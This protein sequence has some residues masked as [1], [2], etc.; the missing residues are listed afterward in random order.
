MHFLDSSYLRSAASQHMAALNR[1]RLSGR[2]IT[3]E[4][5][6][7]S[8]QSARGWALFV[9]GTWPLMVRALTFYPDAILNESGTR[10]DHFSISEV[11]ASHRF[12]SLFRE[13]YK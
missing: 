1:K 5:L 7:A 3:V 6:D 2:W 9:F 13:F 10:T 8:S 11:W 12:S 4:R